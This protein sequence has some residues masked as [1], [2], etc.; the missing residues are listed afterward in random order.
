MV[1][2]AILEVRP[3]E[4]PVNAAV[5]LPGSKSYTNRALIVAAMAE[6]ESLLRQALFSDDTDYMAGALRTLGIKVEE[7][8]EKEQ[9]RIVGA[10]GLI[11]AHRAEVFVGNSGTTARFLTAFLALGHGTYVVDGVERMRQRLIQPLLDGLTQLGVMA[12]SRDGNGCPPV[13]VESDGFPGGVAAIHGDTSSQYFTAI[14]MAAPLSQK[15]V[16]LD[17]IGDLV[18]KPYLDMTGSTMRAFGAEMVNHDCRR[19]E[20]AGGQRY[21][22]RSYDIEP[23][24]SGASYFLAAAAVTGGKVRVEHLGKSSAQGDLH[25]VDILERMGCTVVR[26]EDFTEVVGPRQLRGVDV[27]MGDISDT[28][29]TLAAIAPFADGPVTIRGIAHVRVKET[30]RVAAVATELRRLGLRVD[31][32]QD[33]LT[34]HPGPV[35]PADIET[36][37]DHRMAMSFAVAGLRLPGLRI[38]DPD[39][40]SKT[41]PDFWE[42]FAALFGN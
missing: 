11:P 25:F 22:A 40:V 5:T 14:L 15:G 21:H 39:C 2:K 30:D 29:Q 38:K 28:A 24:A 32:R 16:T 18:S 36:Y 1:N 9:F 35:H 10:E 41:F 12:Y 33:G 20:V 8:R 13:I 26:A 6:G 4:R 7:D 19:F 3:A 17:V 27:D 42:R 31:E 34:V 37:D 23:D